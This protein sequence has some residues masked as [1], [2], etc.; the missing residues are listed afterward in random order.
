M[1]RCLK[2]IYLHSKHLRESVEKKNLCS[3][4][5]SDP[6][7]GMIK[8]IILAIENDML[9][10]FV[11]SSLFVLSFWV[12]RTTMLEGKHD[13]KCVGVMRYILFSVSFVSL[14]VFRRALEMNFVLIFVFVGMVGKAKNGH[15]RTE[16]YTNLSALIRETGQSR[17]DQLKAHKGMTT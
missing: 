3:I 2:H 7:N 13:L 9:F 11:V 14:F 8:H 5:L 12:L 10:V 16:K 17:S 15:Y 1:L 4:F 6:L